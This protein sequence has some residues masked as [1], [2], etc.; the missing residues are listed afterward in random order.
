MGVLDRT[1]AN[2]IPGSENIIRYPQPLGGQ[3]LSGFTSFSTS[4]RRYFCISCTYT[5][6]FCVLNGAGSV[7]GIS[8]QV[9]IQF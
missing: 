9:K 4:E 3:C 8:G 2:I 7:V 5:S 1:I 6:L